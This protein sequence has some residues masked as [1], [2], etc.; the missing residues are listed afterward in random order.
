MNKSNYH[1]CAFF[2]CM[3]FAINTSWNLNEHF[4][5]ASSRGGKRCRSKKDQSNSERN[6]RFYTSLQ[7][8]RRAHHTMSGECRLRETARASCSGWDTIACLPARVRANS[9]ASVSCLTP[10][11]HNVHSTSSLQL[12][13]TVYSSQISFSTPKSYR[14]LSCTLH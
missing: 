8:L 6:R 14:T 13:T 1:S 7:M 12:L 2:F 5:S 10:P 9:K 3:L 4:R 11:P